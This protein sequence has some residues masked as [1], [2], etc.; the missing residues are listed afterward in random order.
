MES[1]RELIKEDYKRV[2]LGEVSE[3]I[4]DRIVNNPKLLIAFKEI[5]GIKEEVA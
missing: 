5:L 2:G 1:I 4:I 3:D